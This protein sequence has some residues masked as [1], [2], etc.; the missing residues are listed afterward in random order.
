MSV[1]LTFSSKCDIMK[2]IGASCVTAFFDATDRASLEMS[3]AYTVASG[4]SFLMVTAIQPEPVPT[5]SI[6]GCGGNT[7]GVGLTPGK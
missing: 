6:V 3:L 1:V 7:R 2:C 5:S 4:N